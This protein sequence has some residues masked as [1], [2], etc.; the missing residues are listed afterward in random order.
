LGHGL[1]TIFKAPA[2]QGICAVTTI[3]ATGA[4]EGVLTYVQQ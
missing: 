1:S 2:S 3:G 4:F